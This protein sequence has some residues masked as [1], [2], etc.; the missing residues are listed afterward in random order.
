ME[1]GETAKEYRHFFRTALGKDFMA[2]IEKARQELLRK[3][4]IESRDESW[5]LLNQ[6][7]GVGQVETLIKYVQNMDKKGGKAS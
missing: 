5:G 4:S 6:A 2:R 1:M 7:N 3:A